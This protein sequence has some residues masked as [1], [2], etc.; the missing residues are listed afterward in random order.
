MVY[1]TWKFNVISGI[2]NHALHDKVVGHPIVC[3]LNSKEKELVSDMTSNMVLP[4]N[5]L[6]MLKRKRPE[7]C[8]KC[9]KKICNIVQ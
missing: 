2:H 1:E 9:K 4:K 5:I 7:K 6:E 3:I 8:L